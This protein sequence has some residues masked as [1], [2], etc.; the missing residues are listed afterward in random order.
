MNRFIKVLLVEDYHDFD[1]ICNSFLG[2]DTLSYRQ[3][4]QYPL[5]YRPYMGYIG[6]IFNGCSPGDGE[7]AD[8]MHKA[9]VQEKNIE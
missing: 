8:A 4:G 7:I 1:M 5:D 6:V 2:E 3:L 9:G